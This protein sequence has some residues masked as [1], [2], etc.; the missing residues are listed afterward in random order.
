MQ[1]NNPEQNKRITIERLKKVLGPAGDGLLEECFNDDGFDPSV[2]TPEHFQRVF[3]SN[4]FKLT[5]K[6]LQCAM[7]D[8]FFG[9]ASVFSAEMALYGKNANTLQNKIDNVVNMILMGLAINQIGHKEKPNVVQIQMVVYSS[10]AFDGS[11]ASIKAIDQYYQDKGTIETLEKSNG[12]NPGV[13]SKREK[14]VLKKY[15]QF[16][17]VGR[18][19]V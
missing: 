12:L 15:Q 7:R 11:D 1:Q 18:L 8:V 4:R 2:I 5:D 13:L 17:A 14:A 6:D 9:G 10:A 16:K 3:D 19:T